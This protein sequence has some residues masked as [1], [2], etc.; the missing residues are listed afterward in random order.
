MLLSFLG[1]MF[2]SFLIWKKLGV[3]K[4]TIGLGGGLGGKALTVGLKKISKKFRAENTQPE[5]EISA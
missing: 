4:S 1:N 2:L 5:W 3:Q